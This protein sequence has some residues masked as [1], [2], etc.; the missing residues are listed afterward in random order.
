MIL[1]FFVHNNPVAKARRSFANA[2]LYYK[3]EREPALRRM[4]ATPL[5][6]INLKNTTY[7]VRS[8]LLFVYG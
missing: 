3:T 7:S 4:R 1:G 8:L 2:A 6:L 5:G